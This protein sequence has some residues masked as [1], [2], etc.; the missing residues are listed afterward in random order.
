MNNLSTAGQAMR[1]DYLTDTPSPRES[2]T[3]GISWSAVIGGAFVAASMALILTFLGVGLG[4]S[5]ASPWSGSGASAT[6]LGIA[7]IVWLI[8]TQAIAAGLGGYLAGRLRTKWADVHT[9]EVYFRDTAHGLLVWAVG[10]VITAAF[11]TS[12]ASSVVGTTAKAAGA[13]AIGSGAL[14]PAALAPAAL[15]AA[16]TPGISDTAASRPATGNQN[17]LSTSVSTPGSYLTDS[18]FRNDRAGPD[19]G[20]DLRPEVGRIL[21][22]AVRKGSLPT[23]DRTYVAQVIA[24]RNGMTQANAE[25]R[26]DAVFAQAKS[27]AADADLAARTAADEVRQAAAKTALW[28]FVALLTGAFVASVA[29]TIGGRQRDHVAD[30]SP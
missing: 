19:A 21:V 30:S 16:P 8:A 27:A 13:A 11:L 4:L 14:A 1:I 12:A 9:D 10:V 28:I 20:Q 22:E 7:T 17:A 25:L 2:S 3:S 15:G 23:A 18:L 29:A 26:V 5:S 24:S 6:T